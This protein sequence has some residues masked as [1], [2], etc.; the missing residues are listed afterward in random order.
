[1]RAVQRAIAALD[2]LREQADVF[3]LRRENDAVPFRRQEIARG[4]QRRGPGIGR[5]TGVVDVEYFADPGDPCVF[6][7]KT[8]GRIGGEKER[9]IVHRKPDA[10]ATACQT[11]VAERRKIC[12]AAMNDVT[13]VA[14][15]DLGVAPGEAQNLGPANALFQ[16]HHRDGH[17][18]RVGFA[19][20]RHA[21]QQ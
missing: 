2:L 13:A 15:I 12:P 5:N 8:L 17:L 20:L 16:P 6:D 4:D 3:V 11:K 14:H 1:M 7:A 9:V 18:V 19:I 10:I 21:Q